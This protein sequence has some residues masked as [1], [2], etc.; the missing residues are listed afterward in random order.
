M[1]TDRSSRVAAGQRSLIVFSLLAL[2]TSVASSAVNAAVSEWKPENPIEL[3]APNAP[4]GGSDRI[5]RLMQKVMQDQPGMTMNVVNKPG[6]G[7]SIAYNYL[8]Q[9]PGNGHYLV[10]AS[11]ALLTNNIVGRGPSY[12]TLTPVAY[13]FNEYIAVTVT[14]D[15]SLKTGRD[16][17]ARLKNDPQAVS[18]GIATSLGAPNH[19]GVAAAL[20]KGGVDV[21]KLRAVIF[22]S[23]GAATTAMFG[24]HIDVVPLSVAFAASL[25]RNGQVRIIAI[26]APQ[27]LP[28]EL[29][30]VPTWREQ[31]YDAVVSQ[32]RGFVGP[33]DMT[34]PQIAYWERA[35]QRLQESPEWKKELDTNFWQSDFRNS[36]GFRKILEEDNAEL[37]AFLDHIGLVKKK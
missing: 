24:G 16:L 30:G 33:R 13:L 2:S 36:A 14:P 5:L 18:F 28:G 9:H 15:S 25:M 35:F 17:V 6:G 29:A 23:G 10:L 19:Q 11:K 21:R 37:T 8:N 31:G 34:A 7:S 1:M 20:G 26:A 3:I 32:W 12:T 4:G 22:S 27:R